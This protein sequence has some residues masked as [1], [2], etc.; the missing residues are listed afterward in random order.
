MHSANA[1]CSKNLLTKLVIN[2]IDTVMIISRRS[3][4][5]KAAKIL[6]VFILAEIPF[7]SVGCSSPVLNCK[8]GCAGTCEGL[9]HVGC[10]GCR[11]SCH[12]SGKCDEC[13]DFCKGSCHGSCYGSCQSSAKG[14]DT[15]RFKW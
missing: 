3:F 4:F 5:R 10:T 2:I 6:P 15:I 13:S 8:G 14:K 12:Y 7:V 1:Y 9:C 11:A